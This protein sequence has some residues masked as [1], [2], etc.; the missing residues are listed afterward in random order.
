MIGLYPDDASR[1]S[2]SAL[3]WS[4]SP[5]TA[6]SSLVWMFR[7]A[8]AFSRPAAA[9]SLNDLSP[10]PPTSYARPTL[11]DF[12]VGGAPPLEEPVFP[13]GGAV[14]PPLLLLLLQAP[15]SSA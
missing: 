2:R 10:R 6:E 8:F 1:V 11:S 5:C 12:V 13:P 7:A 15:S 4:L 3:A 9:R 14:V